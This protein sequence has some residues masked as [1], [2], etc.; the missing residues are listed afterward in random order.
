M[1]SERDEGKINLII[2]YCNY[3]EAILNRVNNSFDDFVDDFEAQQSISFDILQIGEAINKIS[4]DTKGSN[5]NIQWNKIVG[6]RNIIAHNYGTVD[7]EILFET[8]KHSIPELK[9]NCI[10][11]LNNKKT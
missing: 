10:N 2:S 4:D 9:D 8:A 3:I 5:K 1:L 7:V 6:M 11:I